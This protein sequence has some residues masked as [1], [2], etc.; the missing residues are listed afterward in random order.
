MP[1]VSGSGDS[2]GTFLNLDQNIDQ[3]N[4]CGDEADCSNV[5]SNEANF[6]E[7]S[8]SD[9]SGIDIGQSIQQSNEW[10]GEASCSNEG[11]KRSQCIGIFFS[12]Q[13]TKTLVPT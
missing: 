5:G 1:E 13:T 9:T 6:W 12:L 7:D 8:S 3:S 10:I 11:Q 4:I 2:D